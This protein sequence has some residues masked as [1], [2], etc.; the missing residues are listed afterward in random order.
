MEYQTFKEELC[1]ILQKRT[2]GKKK[3]ILQQVEKNNGVVLDA[4]VLQGE[5]EQV[6]PT[7]YLEELYEIY[8]EGA[9][10]EQIAGRILCEEEKWKEEVEFSL[11]EFED[12]TRAR[13]SIFYKLVNYQMNERMLKRV[14]HIRYLDLAVVFYYRVEQ[15]DFPGG[16][17]LIHNNNLVTWGITKSQ[18]MKDAAFNTSR[19]LPYSFVGMESLIAELSGE[20]LMDFPTEELMYV[21]TNEEKYYGAAV[22]LYPHVLSH[23]GTLLKRN[24]FVLPSSV[25]ECILVPDLGHYTRFELMKMVRE[26]NQNQVEEEEILS[27]QVYYYDRKR[28]ALVM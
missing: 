28:E 25:H 27:Y 13:T 16:S 12:Y 3:V 19:K 22:L 2:E 26:V 14:P 15:G 11:E 10:L 9:T 20:K 5:K 7:I 17:V 1:R 21:L 6:L 8:E 18:L 23:I 24:F 4:V